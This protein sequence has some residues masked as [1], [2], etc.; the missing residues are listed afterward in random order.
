MINY[1]KKFKVFL[2]KKILMKMLP[3]YVDHYLLYIFN[4]YIF[5]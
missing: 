5:R 2:I 1:L 3:F 4:N